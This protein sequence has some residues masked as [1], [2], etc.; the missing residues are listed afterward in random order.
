[1]SIV[2]ICLEK[3]FTGAFQRLIIP[4]HQ[5]CFV[6]VAGLWSLI[7][8]RRTHRRERCHKRPAEM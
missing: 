4:L 7:G 6:S 5:A 8:P 3:T 1:L 2:P